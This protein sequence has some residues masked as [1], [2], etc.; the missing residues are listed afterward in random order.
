MGEGGVQ[1]WDWA[2]GVRGGGCQGRRR[3]DRV[4]LSEA[5]A[6]CLVRLEEDHV[7]RAIRLPTATC[8]QRVG[9][10]PAGVGWVRVESPAGPLDVFNTHLHANY[11]HKYDKGTATG[12]EGTAGGGDAT[13]PEAATD[14]YAA[15]RMAQVGP[16]AQRHVFIGPVGKVRCR[17]GPGRGFRMLPCTFRS[18]P[19]SWRTSWCC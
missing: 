19:G 3:A 13:I 11:S 7:S 9:G 8:W 2:G 14:D 6:A 15:F 12:A 4:R 18:S 16:R 17:D 5:R 1:G 10:L